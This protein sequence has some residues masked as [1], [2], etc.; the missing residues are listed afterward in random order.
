M[1]GFVRMPMLSVELK[2]AANSTEFGPKLREVCNEFYLEF[3]RYV[4][5]V[6]KYFCF[7]VHK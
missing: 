7:Q 3:E 1:E 4:S 5:T 6:N 2:Y